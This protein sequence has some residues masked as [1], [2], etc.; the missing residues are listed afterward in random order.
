MS[1]VI[2]LL[3]PLGLYF[4]M[5]RPQRQ[6]V[7]A[8]RALLANLAPGDRVVTAGGMIGTLVS[9]DGERATVE[10]APGVVLEFLAPAI[11]RRIDDPADHDA[12]E[13]PD[14]L[15]GLDGLDGQADRPSRPTDNGR[16]LDRAPGDAGPAAGPEQGGAA[17]DGGPPP[18]GE[19]S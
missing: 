19:E 18:R 1:A 4:A 16:S 15:S 8:Q 5:I 14:D 3:I 17:P 7:Q 6:R 10:L 11:I 12:M 13:V 9:T 2:L